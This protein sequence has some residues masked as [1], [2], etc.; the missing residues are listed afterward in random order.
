MAKK[1]TI[2]EDFTAVHYNSGV[3]AQN[4]VRGIVMHS[5]DGYYKG[6]IS[7]FRNPQSGGSAHFLVSKE[8]EIRQMVRFADMAWHAGIFDKPIPD[9]LNPNPNYYTLGIELEDEK[10]ASWQ[11]PKAQREATQ[12]LVNLLLSKYGLPKNRVFLHKE[13]NPSRRS[14][15]VGAFSRDWLFDYQSTPEVP[16]VAD[17]TVRVEQIIIDGYKAFTGRDV[18][19]DEKKWRL[20]TW[21]NTYE[22][23]KSITGDGK[24]YELYVL[25]HVLTKE[26]ELKN[27][28]ETDIQRMNQEWQ[29]VVE[30]AKTEALQELTAYETFTLLLSK[31]KGNKQA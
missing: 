15:P 7:W 1:H 31:L 8:G 23:L 28:H 18:K 16:P 4:G 22:F 14:D 21:K 20:E 17:S 25:P 30:S 24:F 29:S 6:T 10:N 27:A 2:I 9:F 12:W 26:A 5:M 3:L 13:L 11:Y 19:D